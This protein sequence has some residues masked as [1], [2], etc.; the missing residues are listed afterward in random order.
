MTTFSHTTK[1]AS[2]FTNSGTNKPSHLWSDDNLPWVD[3]AQPWQD[4][5]VTDA[6][7]NASKNTATFTN[8]AKS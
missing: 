1:N 3:D 7:V 5:A 2:T 6:F 8:S 4:E